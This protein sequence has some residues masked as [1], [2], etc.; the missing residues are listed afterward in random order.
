MKCF[1]D[2]T[3]AIMVHKL[4]AERVQNFLGD[5]GQQWTLMQR[6]TPSSGCSLPDCETALDDKS[7]G[8]TIPQ[9]H[10]RVTVLDTPR[11]KGV[12]QARRGYVLLLMEHV[13]I[14]IERFSLL[15]PMARQNISWV[16]RITHSTGV[17]ANR[18]DHDDDT[19]SESRLVG[20]E[21]WRTCLESLHQESKEKSTML[22][23]VDCH[24]R[25]LIPDICRQ[26]QECAS[27][28]DAATD[29]CVGTDPAKTITDPFEGPIP[30]TM[31]RSKCSHRLTIIA[32]TQTSAL[33]RCAVDTTGSA[34]RT[35]SQSFTV[36]D[37]SDTSTT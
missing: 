14:H 8:F 12:S 19:A 28:V 18:Q 27:R 10:C 32:L 30:M 21:I 35:V 15:P 36:R 34:A 20:P 29:S 26:I 16:G 17:S 31:S 11:L 25:E 37:S 33:K 7:T 4:Y 22:L 2:A 23:R 24:P 3:Y 5:S 13:G 9:Q 6:A 1:D